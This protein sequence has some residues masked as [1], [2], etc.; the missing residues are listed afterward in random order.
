[1]VAGDTAAE[2]T[3]GKKAYQLRKDGLAIVH[4]PILGDRAGGR[5][6]FQIAASKIRL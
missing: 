2:L 4:S 5:H 3:V 6:A 1:V